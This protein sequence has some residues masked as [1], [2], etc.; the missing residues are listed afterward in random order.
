MTIDNVI[1][2][3][4]VFCFVAITF[5]IF[6]LL[7]HKSD[8]DKVYGQLIVVTDPIDGDYIFLESNVPIEDI[9]ALSKVSF[10]VVIKTNSRD[11]QSL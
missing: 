4:I 6:K 5:F 8:A 3:A 9:K 2:A 1:L 10:K 7:I 11:K